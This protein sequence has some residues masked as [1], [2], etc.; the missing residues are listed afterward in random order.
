MVM[1]RLHSLPLMHAPTTTT[2]R[3]DQGARKGPNSE[4]N[5]LSLGGL[6]P[7]PLLL[8][9]VLSVVPTHSVF[10]K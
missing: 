6:L 8:R 5:V 1:I 9:G 3:E 4:T 7:Q 2:E 10:H